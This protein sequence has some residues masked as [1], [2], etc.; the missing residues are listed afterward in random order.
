LRVR[1]AL[2]WRTAFQN[3]IVKDQRAT[4]EPTDPEPATPKHG[5]RCGKT[6]VADRPDGRHVGAAVLIDQ[7]L[8]LLADGDAG[9]LQAQ[10]VDLGGA[11][12]G[13]HHLVVCAVG[14]V[15]CCGRGGGGC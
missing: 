2:R 15:W 14:W 11:A 9:G 12:G 6:H 3:Q 13:H 8:A 10:A 5:R 1:V 4:T 7:H